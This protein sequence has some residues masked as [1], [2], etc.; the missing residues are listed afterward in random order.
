MNPSVDSKDP[1]FQE[2]LRNMNQIRE[3]IDSILMC[4]SA[5]PPPRQSSYQSYNSRLN[6]SWNQRGPNGSSNSTGQ[7]PDEMLYYFRCGGWGHMSFQYPRTGPTDSIFF[8]A[9]RKKWVEHSWEMKKERE[10]ELA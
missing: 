2:V 6:A 4:Q 10:C 7:L 5:A 9:N 8:E 3:K 1:S